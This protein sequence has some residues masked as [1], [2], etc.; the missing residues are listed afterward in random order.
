M[1]AIRQIAENADLCE[2]HCPDCTKTCN[3][4][5]IAT[6]IVSG[7]KET[8]TKTKC[9]ALKAEEFNVAKVVDVCR[10]E[11]C[12]HKNEQNLSGKHVHK[13]SNNYENKRGR[14]TQR[15]YSKGNPSWRY[16]RDGSNFS[17]KRGQSKPNNVN[18]SRCGYHHIAKPCPAKTKQCNHYKK[19]GHFE[20]L[21]RMK[22][23]KEG[24]HVRR[25]VVGQIHLTKAPAVKVQIRN[26]NR[27]L[28]ESEALLDYEADI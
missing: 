27:T 21:C 7:I 14:F 12:A 24:G 4:L 2:G 16:G 28:G 3:G 22:V 25:I 13:V 17:T 1:V 10:T 23:S 19:T 11:E 6:K 20:K 18:C 26:K 9:L 8:E 5:R 15:R